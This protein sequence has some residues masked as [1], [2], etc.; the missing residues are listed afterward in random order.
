MPGGWVEWGECMGGW[1]G[2]VNEW[3]GGDVVVDPP[4]QVL[5]CASF[6][7]LPA[8]MPTQH[9]AASWVKVPGDGSSSSPSSL[10]PP[11]VLTLHVGGEEVIFSLPYDQSLGRLILVSETWAKAIKQ[12]R[13]HMWHVG[14]PYVA[15]RVSICGR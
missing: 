12:V 6:F 8:K 10:P 2:V 14:C 11:T 4:S 5:S 9:R 7:T 13:V 3:V 15:C 1:V